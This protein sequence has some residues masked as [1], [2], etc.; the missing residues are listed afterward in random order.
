MANFVGSSL[1]GR[2]ILS[3]GIREV[4][5]LRRRRTYRLRHHPRGRAAGSADEGDLKLHD[6]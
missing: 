4:G 1:G 5:H 2:P 6:V 3:R